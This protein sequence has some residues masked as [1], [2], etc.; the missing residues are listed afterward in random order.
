V[1]FFKLEGTW[2][3]IWPREDLAADAGLEPAGSGFSGF[4]L[5]HNEPSAEGVDRVY[6]EALAAG[7][8]PVK[9]P[10][11]TFWGGYAGYFADPDGHLW[12]VAYNPF[13]DLT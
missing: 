9:P 6:A 1:V 12:E 13:T 7:A 11:E 4:S 8:K 3:A 10:T 5:A 2:L